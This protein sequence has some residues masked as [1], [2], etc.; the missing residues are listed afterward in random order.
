MFGSP[1][2]LPDSDLSPLGWRDEEYRYAL[3]VDVLVV[4][5]S[6]VDQGQ[7]GIL[8][9]GAYAPY[10][11]FWP[12]LVVG[13]GS[14]INP[15]VFLRGH[16]EDYDAWGSL[17][18]A[19]WSWQSILPYFL[20]PVDLTGPNVQS[21][22]FPAPC[23]VKRTGG[24]PPMKSAFLR[25]KIPRRDSSK[26]NREVGLLRGL[27][28]TNA[29]YNAQPEG[30]LNQFA[31]NVGV[32]TV[33]WGTSDSALL[34]HLKPLSRG[35]VN[36]NSTD[37]LASPLIDFRTATD[38]IDL[39]VYTTVFRKNRDLFAAPAMQALGPTEAAP[40]GA[41]LTTDEP[42][43]RGRDAQSNLPDQC[44][45]VLHGCHAV[46]Q[47]DDV[48]SSEQKVYG[49]SGLRVCGYQL[50]GLSSSPVRPRRPSKKK[51][52]GTDVL[53]FDK[54]KVFPKWDVV[55]LSREG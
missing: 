8:V 44:P 41:H 50:P 35:T 7:D 53:P 2:R 52:R 26:V 20:K 18:N 54:S 42:I 29:T 34:Y 55:T 46:R 45:P 31:S 1:C 27:P 17:G 33:H 43:N 9:S 16:K 4:E 51:M 5:A 30:I 37:P 11:Y 32:G 21:E 49:I 10:L 19:G 28:A 22:N 6:P 15:M 40:S 25:S 13:G 3:A 36:I 24:T 14:T 39:Q 47:L 48:V 38:P 23:L 12:N